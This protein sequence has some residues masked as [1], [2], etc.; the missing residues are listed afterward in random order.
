MEDLALRDL[1]RA[2]IN[3]G[4]LPKESFRGTWTD[5]PTSASE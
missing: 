5:K 2:K 4:R 1:I 3:D